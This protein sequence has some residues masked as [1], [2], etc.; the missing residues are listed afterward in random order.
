M[1][2]AKVIGANFGAFL[3]LTCLA[4]HLQDFSM[5]FSLG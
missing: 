5:P 1:D 2:R 4:R 3:A